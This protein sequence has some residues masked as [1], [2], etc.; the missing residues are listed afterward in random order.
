M[1]IEVTDIDQ[2]E[3]WTGASAVLDPG[4]YNVRIERAEEVTSSG[5]HDQ[6]ELEMSD[7]AGAGSIRDWLTFARDDFGAIKQGS[8]ARA[9]AVLDAVGI[10]AQ[11]GTWAFP[12]QA[13][14][15]KQCQIEI[16]ESP[17]LDGSGTRK[18]V[19]SYATAGA[20]PTGATGSGV[21]ADTRDL[22]GVHAQV[23][24]DDK[25]PF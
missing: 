19:F 11:S 1:T 10:V 7:L 8:L 4:V 14:V 2:V 17:K 6:V 13:L 15:G 3:G 18:E 16:V 24:D 9:R 5:G 25:I 22:P 23:S 20:Q 21:P 12:T